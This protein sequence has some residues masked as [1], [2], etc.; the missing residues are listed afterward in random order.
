MQ[1]KKR[2]QIYLE[3]IVN[4][5]IQKIAINSVPDVAIWN[6]NQIL[7]I[8]LSQNLANHRLLLPFLKVNFIE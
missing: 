4:S 1:V 5:Y 2:P 7:L 6:F 3:Y 8:L